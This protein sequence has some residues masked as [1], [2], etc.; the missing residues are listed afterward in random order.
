M[1]I[2]QLLFTE[3]LVFE[4]SHIMLPK[5]QL[6]CTTYISTLQEAESYCLSVAKRQYSLL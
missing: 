3:L 2:N 5:S 4:M 6:L 1:H